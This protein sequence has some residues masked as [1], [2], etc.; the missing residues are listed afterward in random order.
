MRKGQDSL[1]VIFRRLPGD[2]RAP[3]ERAAPI[4]EKHAS[5]IIL[6]AS[7]PIAI[8]CADGRYYLTRD[9]T[10]TSFSHLDILLKTE[11]EDILNTFKSI[12]DYSVYARQ[13]E[14]NRGFITIQNGVRVGICGTAVESDNGIINIKDITTLSFRV[15][16]EIIGC[17]QEIIKKVDPLDGILIYGPPCSGKTTMIRDLSRELSFRYKVSIVDERNE[18]SATHSGVSGYDIGMSDVFVGLNKGDGIIRALR[19]MSPEIIVCDELGDADD[20]M[21]LR[22]ALRCGVSFIAT[23]HA[24]DREELYRRKAVR[25]LISTGAFRYAVQLSDRRHA[26]EILGIDEIKDVKHEALSVSGTGRRFAG[27]KPVFLRKAVGANQGT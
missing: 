25:E 24:R 7:R 4:F 13:R 18:I 17:S 16:R 23:V 22:Y 11:R 15:A 3:I 27:D 26:G 6:R 19:S 12:C 9:G 14:L 5:E 21:H 1:N 8:E 2:I 10:V 20:A